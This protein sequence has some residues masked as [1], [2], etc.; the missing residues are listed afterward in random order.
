MVSKPN[1]HELI[2]KIY[3]DAYHCFDCKGKDEIDRG[4]KLLYNSEA[5]KDAIMQV[6]SFLAKYLR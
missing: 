2:L 5:A 4:H 3:P 1:K 6:K